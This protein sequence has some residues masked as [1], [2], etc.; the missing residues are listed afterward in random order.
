LNAAFEEVLRRPEI[1]T[2][3]LA[4]RFGLYWHGQI[5]VEGRRSNHVD[6]PLLGPSGA[7]N[8]TVF[9]EQAELTLKALVAGGKKVLWIQDVPELGFDPHQCLRRPE[10]IARPKARCGID[11]MAY[12]QRTEGY[13]TLLKSLAARYPG[14]RIWDSST[15]LCEKGFCSALTDMEMLYQ[16]D[17]HLNVYGSKKVGGRLAQALGALP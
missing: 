15:V 16:D 11:Q 3:V 10:W 2:V 12:E 5:P 17:D 8:P 4:G 14:V 1:E 7:D 9:S 13:K 6:F